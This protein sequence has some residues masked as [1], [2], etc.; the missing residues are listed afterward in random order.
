MSRDLKGFNRA[1]MLERA[2]S[3][4]ET[5]ANLVGT[6]WRLGPLWWALFAAIDE[7]LAYCGDIGARPESDR[8]RE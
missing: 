8:V 1:A 4:F 5:R 6:V 2:A 7:A 3:E